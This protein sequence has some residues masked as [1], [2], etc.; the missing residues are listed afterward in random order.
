MKQNF[1][2]FLSSGDINKVTNRLY[3]LMV[4]SLVV[5]FASNVF[6]GLWHYQTT[7]D[8]DQKVYVRSGK[9]VFSAFLEAKSDT[10]NIHQAR[11][12]VEACMSLL[13]ATNAENYKEQV[14]EALGLLTAEDGQA[15][16]RGFNEQKVLE[17]HV[18]Y[19]SFAKIDIDSLSINMNVVPYQCQ[20]LLRQ[21]IYY[22]GKEVI[23]PIG[24]TFE[25]QPAL[26][27]DTNPF[28]LLISNFNYIV[29]QPSE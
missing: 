10:R 28:G 22:D 25:L 29:Y 16:V 13:Y 20:V 19:N 5:L 14:N 18:R 24:T 2:T 27:S 21:R 6:W 11:G 4:L 9:N 3:R 15:I 17:N 8:A 26:Y 1:E 23:N 7:K 12:M